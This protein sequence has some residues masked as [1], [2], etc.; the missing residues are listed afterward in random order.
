MEHFVNYPEIIIKHAT[1]V[2]D[3]GYLILGTP[4]FKGAVQN[5]FHFLFDQENYQ[6]HYIPSMDP[7]KWK[8]ILL[9]QNFKI[10]NSGYLGN[11]SFWVDYRQERKG[12]N[13]IFY[14]I[15]SRLILLGKNIK[16][17]SQFFS[18]YCYLIA[19]KQ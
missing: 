2:N 16:F 12:L 5:I 15:V 4:N 9:Q 13:K 17:N 8:K 18:P 3:G 14:K 10:I 6:K 19:K 1:L 7:V 11:F